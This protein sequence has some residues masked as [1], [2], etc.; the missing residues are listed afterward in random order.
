[1]PVRLNPFQWLEV[2]VQEALPVVTIHKHLASL[3]S[4]KLRYIHANLCGSTDCFGNVI[5]ARY[6]S[7]PELLLKQSETPVRCK[8]R[9]ADDK[10]MQL[11][12][13]MGST[14]CSPA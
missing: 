3:I 10:K 9:V 1:M 6:F 12:G 14:Q 11:H 5:Q 13:G 8:L 2:W 4:N 7:A